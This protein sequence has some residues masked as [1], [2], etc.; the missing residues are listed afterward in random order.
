MN[1]KRSNEIEKYC[2]LCEHST[3]S[4]EDDK[5]LCDIKG[6]VSGG[7]KCRKYRYDPLKRIPTKIIL[8]EAEN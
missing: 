8:P 5:V 4:Y 1:Q 7:H 6:I 2:A 3:P